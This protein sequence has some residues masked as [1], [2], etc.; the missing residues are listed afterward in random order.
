MTV[1]RISLSRGQLDFYLSEVRFRGLSAGYAFG[2]SYLMGLCAVSDAMHSSKAVIG[3][4]EPYHDLVRTVAWPNVQNW[5]VEFGI[6]FNLNKQENVIYTSNSGVGDFYFK[7]MDNIDALVGYET[8]SSHIDEIDTMSATNAEKAFFKIMGRNRQNLADVPQEYKKYN[9]RLKRWDCNNRISVY[10]TPEGYKFL[11]KMWHP[12]GENAKKNPEF[13]LFYG[14]TLDNSTL[15][16][17]F[18]EGLRN[19]YPEKLLTAY[20][21]GEF[22]NLETGTVYYNF[23]RKEHNTDRMIRSD[24]ILHIGVDFNVNNTTGIVSVNDGDII[25]VV[26][27]VTK[28]YDTPALARSIKAR[29]PNHRIICY[30][31]CSGGK[32]GG[33]HTANADLSDIVELRNTGF[34]IRGRSKNPLIR[35]R[36]AA[37]VKKIEKNEYFVNVSQC[38]VYTK[39]LE[40]QAYDEKSGQPDKDT[41]LDHPNDAAGYRIWYTDPVR[42]P[43]FPIKVSFS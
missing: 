13:K 3:V 24:D 6:R 22:V 5:L 2:K 31:D 9:E 37:K 8:Y 11:Y 26:A 4:Y 14:R 20:M 15:N 27:E 7:S 36:V 43:L 18:V 33:R 32:D 1:A 19:T 28:Q 29:W 10:S 17:S 23:D 34:E 21:E 30:P 42:K 16:E 39:C 38:P 41:G 12:D 25:S 40:Q 35:D